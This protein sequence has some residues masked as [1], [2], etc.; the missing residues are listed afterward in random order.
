MPSFD[1]AMFDVVHEVWINRDKDCWAGEG[2]C[3]LFWV[4]LTEIN[5]LIDGISVLYC[6]RINWIGIPCPC[7]RRLKL[8]LDLSLVSLLQ[9]FKESKRNTIWISSHYRP[10]FSFQIWSY[11]L[12]RPYCESF[13][14]IR[15]FLVWVSSASPCGSCVLPFLTEPSLDPVIH[16]KLVVVVKV[17]SLTFSQDHLGPTLSFDVTNLP[18]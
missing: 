17:K 1:C 6:R 7:D 3:A 9:R 16:Y 8:V 2:V 14:W 15:H 10:L 13:D 11:S 5:L 18:R 4:N 12:S